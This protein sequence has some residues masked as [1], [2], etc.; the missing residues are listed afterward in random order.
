MPKPDLPPPL[1]AFISAV[2]AGDSEAAFSFFA[3]DAKINDWG[4]RFTTPRAIRAWS[5]REFI[6]AKGHLSVTQVV[7]EGDRVVVDA[8]WRSA[9]YAGDSRFVFTLR[10]GSIR[11]MRIV[12]T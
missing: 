11:E 5:D 8:G 4:R 3:S 1:D 12:D 7:R 6:G 10:D 9:I 2:N